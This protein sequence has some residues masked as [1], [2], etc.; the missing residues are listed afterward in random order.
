MA[1][2]Q[3]PAERK[4]QIVLDTMSA[5]EV[6]TWIPDNDQEF[7]KISEAI[8]AWYQLLLAS[9]IIRGTLKAKSVLAS[10]MLVLGT[11]IKYTYALGL[12]RGEW[13]QM[14]QQKRGR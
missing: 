14:T 11:L 1:E 6:D 4:I 9:G 3:N 7:R 10:S 8:M 12:R 5:Q 2:K 13:R